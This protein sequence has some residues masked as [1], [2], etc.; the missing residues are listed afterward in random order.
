M[1]T[2]L[3]VACEADTTSFCL[4]LLLPPSAAI[5]GQ[6]PPRYTR[7]RCIRSRGTLRHAEALVA[8]TT[9]RSHSHHKVKESH[10]LGSRTTKLGS[11]VRANKQSGIETRTK[12]QISSK[13]PANR[14]PWPTRTA[15][16]GTKYTAYLASLAKQHARP[17]VIQHSQ[18]QRMLGDHGNSSTSVSVWGPMG[19]RESRDSPNSL[20]RPQPQHPQFASTS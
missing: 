19:N 13:H 10:D 3:I 14:L 1:H 8:D 6:L 16:E 5:V 4:S 20:N 7:H 15:A 2:P 17:K 9:C 18:K 11:I 12:D